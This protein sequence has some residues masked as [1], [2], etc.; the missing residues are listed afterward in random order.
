MASNLLKKKHN[1]TLEKNN[2]L[3]VVT[4]K[5]FDSLQMSIKLATLQVLAREKLILVLFLGCL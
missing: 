5:Q 4:K 3:I 1:V 2:K